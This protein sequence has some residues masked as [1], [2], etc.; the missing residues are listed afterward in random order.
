MFVKATVSLIHK[1]VAEGV[2]KAFQAMLTGL[3]IGLG[4]IIAD[5]LPLHHRHKKLRLFRKKQ[6]VK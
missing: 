3:A 6:P 1:D 5:F 2:S 4:M